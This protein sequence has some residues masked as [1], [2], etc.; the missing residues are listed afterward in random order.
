MPR[1]DARWL[2]WRESWQYCSIGCGGKRREVYE[3]LH[4]SQKAT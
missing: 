3:P 4:N 1:N 2:P